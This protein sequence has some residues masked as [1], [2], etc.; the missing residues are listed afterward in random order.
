MT[1]CLQ[2]ASAWGQLKAG[3]RVS[4]VVLLPGEGCASGITEVKENE[5]GRMTSLELYHGSV[6]LS[7]GNS[8]YYTFFP[9]LPVLAREKIAL[10]GEVQLEVL[11]EKA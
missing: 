2:F 3:Y 4:E 5:P 6:I 7:Y 8:R 1:V 9:P 11:A 10:C